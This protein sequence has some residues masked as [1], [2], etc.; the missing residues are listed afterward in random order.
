MT[1]ARDWIPLGVVLAQL[2]LYLAWAFT[3]P[4]EEDQA[5]HPTSPGLASVAR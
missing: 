2:L 1:D 5:A 4:T 3:D